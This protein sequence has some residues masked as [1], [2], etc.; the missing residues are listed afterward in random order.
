M[1]EARCALMGLGDVEHGVDGDP[2]GDGDRQVQARR[3]VRPAA[4]T[5]R[6]VRR[7]KLPGPGA[8][9]SRSGGAASGGGV[10][11]TATDPQRS[12]G[13]EG[14]PRGRRLPA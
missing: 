14:P 13:G 6:V 2:F 10:N 7:Q 8:A 3:M 4:Q 11:E 5:G 1:R 12:G 9:G